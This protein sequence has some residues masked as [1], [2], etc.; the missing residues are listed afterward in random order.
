MRPPTALEAPPACAGLASLSLA[1]EDGPCHPHAEARLL[2]AEER[3]LCGYALGWLPT[4]ADVAASDEPSDEPIRRTHLTSPSDEA[5][6]H[7]LEHCNT[8][9]GSPFYR[10]PEQVYCL[11]PYPTTYS[12]GV[13]VW[14]AGVVLLASMR[15]APSW[16]RHSWLAWLAWLAW[17]PAAGSP[18]SWPRYAL[19]TLP[20]S[21]PG[22]DGGG[23]V[24]VRL[25]LSGRVCGC[26]LAGTYFLA[27]TSPLTRVRFPGHRSRR[28]L[29]QRTPSRPRCG[30]TRMTLR[31]TPG[32]STAVAR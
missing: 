12:T 11:P 24:A 32:S 6:G 14:S 29:P 18:G 22:P 10:A 4:D 7:G 20:Q 13:D 17:S 9:V 2:C 1:P 25:C 28:P 31:P 5:G 23:R 3:L 27:R 16:W 19:G 21:C 8:R 30:G 26:H 15:E